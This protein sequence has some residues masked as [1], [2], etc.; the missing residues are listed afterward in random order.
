MRKFDSKTRTL[1]W[2]AEH[3]VKLLQVREKPFMNYGEYRLARER[4][5]MSVQKTCFMCHRN[6]TDDADMY[7]SFWKRHKNM[8]LCGDCNSIAIN[9]LT[10]VER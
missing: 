1:K 2:T 6:F 9:S 3:S 10:E 8:L 7:I 4:M 5:K